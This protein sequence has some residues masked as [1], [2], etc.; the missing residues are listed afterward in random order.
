[1]GGA[2]KFEESQSLPDVSYATFAAALGFDTLTIDDP[3]QLGPAW[4]RVLGGTGPALLDVHC[5]PEV[6]PIPPHATLEQMT[7]TAQAL[8]KGD[9]NAWHVLM[10]GAKTKLQEFLPGS[11]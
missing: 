4:D 1:M 7:S 9:P 6:P 11:R 10:Q 2:P 3:D 5:D 8:V